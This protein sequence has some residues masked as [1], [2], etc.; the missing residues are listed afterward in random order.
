MKYLKTFENFTPIKINS[1]KPF[2][3]NKKLD[4]STRVLQKGIKSLKNMLSN[5]KNDYKWKRRTEINNGITTKSKKLADLKFQ[6]LKQAEYLKNNPNHV[7]EDVDTSNDNLISILESPDFKPEDILKHIGLDEKDYEIDTDYHRTPKYDNEGIIF[8]INNSLLEDLMN[9]EHGFIDYLQQITS[10]YSGYEY[11]V[12]DDELNYIDRYL[13]DDTTKKIKELAILFDYQI[14]TEKDTEKEGEIKEFFEYLGLKR[15]LDDVKSE[16]SMENER[17][18]EAAAK[19]LIE[20]L[21]FSISP[22]YSG[23]KKNLEIEIDYKTIIDYMKKYKIDVKT[24]KELFE[25]L[26]ESS[27]FSYDFEYEGKY[28]F[29]GDFKDVNNVVETAMENYV[30]NPDEV[31]VKLIECDNLELFKE[32]IELANFTYTYDTWI[33]YNR[34]RF[35]LFDLAKH[36]NKEIL[37][38]F[39]SYEFQNQIISDKNDT[40]MYKLLQQSNIIDPKIEKEFSYLVDSEKYNL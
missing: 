11:Y 25:N 6:Q 18:V 1:H 33:D 4:K 27:D 39:K 31:F 40:E 8:L 10:S 26:E 15:L 22:K 2:K 12:D 3:V 9:I 14:D 19:N 28:D 16:I 23:S 32:K 30:D 5:K 29:L 34:N 36:Y 7:N 35:I 17:A 13:S 20:S 37:Q 24:L 21:P 38:W